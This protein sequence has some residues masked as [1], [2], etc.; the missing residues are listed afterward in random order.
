MEI[1][2]SGHYG[3]RRIVRSVLPSIGMV[4]I[5]SIY[6]IVDGFFISNFAGKS[7]F[8]AINLMWPAMMM[9][10]SLGLMVGSGGGALVAK[11]KG[12]GYTEKANRIFTMLVRFVLQLGIVTGALF[13]LFTPT[14]ARWLG[15]DAAMMD[16]CIIYGRICMIGMPGFVL[17][18]AFQ[19]F[20]MAAERPQLGT[21]M[22]IVSGVVNIALDALLVW[23]L[24]W[25]VAGAAIATAIAQLV[26]GIYPLV[27]FSSKRL[28]RGSLKMLR[29]TRV[30]WPYIGKAC[31]N[32]L[33][34]Y[35]SNIAMSIV[36]ICYNLQLMRYL[37]EDG[38]AAYGIVMYIAFV[39][40]AVFIGYNIAITP[41]I[42]YHYGARDVGE[43]RSLFR[44]SLVIIGV[45]G[46]VMTLLAEIFSSGYARLFV[47]YDAELTVLTTKAIRY[48]MLCFLICG[49][50][51]FASAM[52]T[53]MQNGFISAVAAL[54]RSMV[55][56]LSCV[57]VLPALVGIDGIWWAVDVAEVLTL[58]LCA[59]LVSRYAPQIVSRRKLT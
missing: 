51:M 54:A 40:A 34:E 37:G 30:I 26:G 12:E 20:Y 35:V 22:S 9:L 59:I 49:W 28:N 33:S 5:T 17:Q 23:A 4:L 14:L 10:G 46:V 19:S 3:Y 50:S 21:V 52:F 57:W 16:E 24:R 18:M 1:T 53:G 55:F 15:S 45:I 41:I 43:Q 8:A 13:A 48:Y 32:G 31:S 42:G 27:Y 58:I 29:H 56:E 25:G 44:K 39:Y 7:G 38:V 47:G 2:L 6:S 36:S 11:V